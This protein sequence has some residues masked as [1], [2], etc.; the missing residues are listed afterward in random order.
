MQSSL[1]LLE[2]GVC[3]DQLRKKKRGRQGRKGKITQLNA[4]FQGISRKEKRAFLNEQ[5]TEIE[6]NYR[7]VKVRDVF[8]E[9]SRYQGNISCKDGHNKGQN[10]FG[11]NR[12]R[13]D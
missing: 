2:K 13:S 11:P 8:Q 9:N 4:E 10:W 6:E 5:C 1:V 12:S 7:I 3:C